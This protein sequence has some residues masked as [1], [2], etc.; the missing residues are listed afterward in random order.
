MEAVA[1]VADPVL[2]GLLDGELAVGDVGVPGDVPA[3]GPREGVAVAVGRG[4]AAL[5]G[6][7]LLRAVALA[8]HHSVARVAQGA[9]VVLAGRVLGERGAAGGEAGPGGGGREVGGGGVVVRGEV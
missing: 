5:Q 4:D 3:G 6:L 8:V 2:D 9:R 1:V 7:R